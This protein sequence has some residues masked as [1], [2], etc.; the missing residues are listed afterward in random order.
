[1]TASCYYREYQTKSKP[2]KGEGL[3]GVSDQVL[4]CVHLALQ[5]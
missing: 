3:F 1:M 2:E 5:L 4:G